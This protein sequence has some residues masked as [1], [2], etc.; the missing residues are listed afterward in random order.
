V[1]TTTF[2]YQTA[3]GAVSLLLLL[4]CLV[5]NNSV[6]NIKGKRNDMRKNID[7]SYS[8]YIATEILSTK[9]YEVSCAGGSKQ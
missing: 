3:L 8:G 7:T 9:E 1:F 5:N 4:R 6:S 2:F